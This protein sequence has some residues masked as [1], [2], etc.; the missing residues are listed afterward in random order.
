M[1]AATLDFFLEDVLRLQI[2][3][4]LNPNDPQDFIKIVAALTK[5]TK[6]LAQAA[7]AKA[8]K[9]AL[10]AL[11]VDW[12]SMKADAKAKVVAAAKQALNPTAVVLPKI[13]EHFEANAI[14]LGK[15]TKGET[16]KQFGFSVDVDL[17]KVEQETLWHVALSHA[18]YVT[19]EYG[20]RSD[21]FGLKAKE[22][23]ARGLENGMGRK[24]LAATLK[25]QLSA[26]QF[27]R[28]E[29][30]WSVV[31]GAFANR[32]R[33][34]TN[35]STYEEAGVETFEID[36]VLDERTSDICRL[37]HGKRFTVSAA[38][39]T[40]SAGDKGDQDVKVSQP[41]MSIGRDDEGG[42]YIYYR[43]KDGD[44]K[45]V[46]NIAE[47]GMGKVGE[48]GTFANEMSARAMGKAGLTT[49][50]FHGNCRTTVNPVLDTGGVVTSAPGNFV[51]PPEPPPP[52]FALEVQDPSTLPPLPDAEPTPPPPKVPTGQFGFK[53]PEGGG[54]S[55]SAGIVDLTPTK[56]TDPPVK[57]YVSP[58]TKKK[59]ALEFLEL[60]HDSGDPEKGVVYAPDWEFVTPKM[61]KEIDEKAALIAEA[62]DKADWSKS[63]LKGISNLKVTNNEVD[64]I[65][66]KQ[67][68]D[69]PKL[70][71]NAQIKVLEMTGE[72]VG[73][74][75]KK[76]LVVVADPEA[77]F[78]HQLLGK[79]KVN[80]QIVSLKEFEKLQKEKAKA[81]ALKPK[82]PAPPP[83]PP[84]PA[85]PPP[86]VGPPETLENLLHNKT[87]GP[88]GSNDGG[89]YTGKD[90]KE[91]Y[92]KFYQDEAQAH[93]EVLANSLY[94]SLGFNSPNAVTLKDP[95]GKNVYAV[96][97]M[98]G[99][100][101]GS[102]GKLTKENARE[103]MK[104]F[105]ADVLM[106]NWDAAGLSID[107]AFVLDGGKGVIR[108]DNG[109]S[110][111][112]RAKAGRKPDNV[113]GN[114]SE[115]EL[116]FD[117][118]K[119]PG[120]SKVAKM[121]GY[122]SPDDFKAEVVKQIDDIVKLRS[123]YGGWRSYVEQYAPALNAKDKGSIID[124]L[125]KRTDLLQKRAFELSQPPPPK[126]EGQ[127][128]DLPINPRNGK[129]WRAPSLEDGVK[130]MKGLKPSDLPS[131]KGPPQPTCDRTDMKGTMPWGEKRE[132]YQKRGA[133]IGKR[134]GP[135]ALKAVKGFSNGTYG[136]VRASEEKGKPN[137][138]SA[139]IM[140]GFERVKDKEAI[141]VY[142]GISLSEHK[143]G[144]GGPWKL[145]QAMIENDGVFRLGNG[146][147]EGTSS[148]AWHP[149][150]SVS[151]MGG[152]SDPTNHKDHTKG[153]YKVFFHIHQRSGMQIEKISSYGPEETEVLLPRDAQFRIRQVARWKGK[154]R[155]IM[156]ELEE[157]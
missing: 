81:E 38:K 146:N 124:M 10:E 74:Y 75:W 137:A 130:P 111:L 76:N 142:R 42:Q 147:T 119:N 25:E 3:K 151:F 71:K 144:A 95:T 149:D 140:E 153:D 84:P 54:I 152:M 46:A 97:I 101:L 66:V 131:A 5:A 82:A 57:A 139:A 27:N 134:M 106:G 26:Q 136:E 128:P 69:N 44:R 70:L 98:K 2:K 73:T 21:A 72:K 110:F 148:S 22:I 17:T 49:P 12:K 83:P 56:P 89:F 43:N 88:K 37:M 55:N 68:L 102:P 79:D 64:P 52:P 67:Y 1:L 99:Q 47:S 154:E 9:Q 100:T 145:L 120:Y 123:K 90:G 50:P 51:Q 13:K 7:E 14:A 155:I 108:I 6:G 85:V 30:Y 28:S 40:F 53:F 60:L 86:V 18:N 34:Y 33:V 113:L 118:Y 4:A 138:A 63:A 36:A 132:D 80:V 135:D 11:D 48:R 59:N 45:R 129:K 116:F 61:N 104:G 16:V 112:M 91:R 114:I 93:G 92:V 133:E 19:D 41:W 141:T 32:A 143:F 58:A 77:M 29:A 94:R 109:G 125:E 103:F 39:S 31:A 20:K 87:G 65:K 150:T 105:A 8:L 122:D 62:I 117:A 126:V 96:D 115:W 78:A 35:L 107:N 23:I 24:E 157:I 15:T 121:A 127:K 156:I